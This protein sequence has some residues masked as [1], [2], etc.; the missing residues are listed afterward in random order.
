MAKIR[1]YE[2]AKEL[3]LDNKDVLARLRDMKVP[4]KSHMSVVPEDKIQQIKKGIKE[5]QKVKPKGG[6]EEKR[7]AKGVIRRRSRPSIEQET[8]EPEEKAARMDL[9]T[10]KQ[11]AKR[12]RREEEEETAKPEQEVLEE[13]PKEW[14][15]EEEEK[16]PK[17]KK[18]AKKKAAAKKKKKEEK[19]P[20]EKAAKPKKKAATKKT[21]AAAPEKPAE[22]EAEAPAPQKKKPAG[23]RRIYMRP[24]IRKTARAAEGEPLPMPG[25]E[26]P[27]RPESPQD[28]PAA[29]LA[30]EPAAKKKKKKKKKPRKEEEAEAD[31]YMEPPKKRLRRKIAF[32]MQSGMEGM[33]MADIEQMYM[34]SK[35]KIT[36]KKK[37]AKKTEITTPKALK[38]VVKMGEFIS[39]PEL[40]RQ[41]GVKLTDIKNLMKKEGVE[42]ENNRLDADSAGVLAS[43]YQYE[44]S[45]ELFD[46]RKVLGLEELYQKTL[47][48]R[49]RPPVVTVMG[50]VDHGKTSL[51]D[52]IRK[53]RVT[54]SEAGAITQH[55]GASMVQTKNGTVTFIDTP[56]HEAFT[57]MRMRGARV[58]DIVV[59]VVAADDG[60]MPQTVEAANHAKAAGAPIIV[61]INKIDLPDANPQ[62][63][64]QR[65]MEIELTPEDWGGDT[66]VVECSA[67]SGEG[68][69]D[70]LESILLQAEVLELAADPE[71]PLEG[72]VI[73]SRLDKGRGPVATVIV[74]QGAL[75]RGDVIIA[76]AHYGKARAMQDDKGNQIKQAGPGT[77]VE[78][79]GLS[80]VPEP[81]ETVL[82]AADEKR[83]REVAQHRAAL[84]REKEAD[85]EAGRAKV[86]LEDLMARLEGREVQELNLVLKADTNG[87]LEAIRESTE[88]LSGDEV[89][90]AVLHTGVGNV[91][92][93]DV[94]LA[95]ASEAVI[96]GFSIKVEA[97]ASKLS[98]TEGVQIKTYDVIYELIDDLKASL[99][100][101][102]KPV[103]KENLL[104]KAE[105]RKVFRVAKVG[106]VAGS[107][108]IEGA[109]KRNAKARVRRNGDTVYTGKIKSLKRE[110]EDAREV[111]QGL[112]CGIGLENFNEV[113]E[114]DTIEVFEMTEV[115]R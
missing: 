114:G 70:L 75:K 92:E 31:I 54:E 82:P 102:L 3:G 67:K 103:Y 25:R 90:V 88:K 58:T 32:K 80:G 41:M 106:A 47:N 52:A 1:V 53:T 76:G 95:S 107:Y 13:I 29:R 2:L 8:K 78:I 6:I 57:A 94:L 65:L 99:K 91:T 7:V 112:E 30:E 109:V 9:Q 81:G 86:S 22:E 104:G 36:S 55:I 68:L 24:S 108:V 37:T 83:A 18:T 60:I 66:M 44:V 56:G 27:P 98:Q 74:K 16:A 46:E 59:L 49:P 43:H 45:Q 77:A 105:V 61:A 97:G 63:V 79:M 73:E 96:I 85:K 62:A 51:L 113:Q 15:E 42:L 10:L 5:A 110:Q 20:A 111:L 26:P 40:A 4:V 12:A 101:M 35:K 23:P 38:R 84:A 89:K 33:E 93:N 48:P 19:E 115:P 21:A 71:A 28:E 11:A 50:H 87:S 34:P 64:K 100:G 17:K 72:V 14:A 69:A 39:P